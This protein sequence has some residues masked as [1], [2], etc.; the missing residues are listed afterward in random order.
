MAELAAAPSW[1]GTT[2]YKTHRSQVDLWAAITSLPPEKHGPALAL[3][4]QGQPHA[5]ALQLGVAVLSKPNGY[6]GLLAEL[7]KHYL[8]DKTDHVY[9]DITN[10]IRMSRT[11]SDMSA[12]VAR[13]RIL[14]LAAESHLA[15]DAHFPSAFLSVLL[16]DAAGLSS[17]DRKLVMAAARGS[18]D[19]K[20]IAGAMRR[21]FTEHH[22]PQRFA[23]MATDMQGV[24]ADVHGDASARNPSGARRERWSRSAGPK[25]P[26]RLSESSWADK[27]SSE[28]ADDLQRAYIAYRKAR[29]KHKQR[30][31]ET[32]NENP[33]DRK[34]GETL[35]CF[36]CGDRTHLVPRCPRRGT[37]DVRQEDRTTNRGPKKEEAMAAEC[38]PK[39]TPKVAATKSAVNSSSWVVI[40]SGAT[41][42]LL[43]QTWMQRH[44]EW[45]RAVG[46]TPVDIEPTTTQF[47]FGNG[48]IEAVCGTAAVP[49]AIGGQWCLLRAYVYDGSRPALLSCATLARMGAKVDFGSGHVKFSCSQLHH[50][51]K[52]THSDSGHLLLCVSDTVGDSRQLVPPGDISRADSSDAIFASYHEPAPAG[53]HTCSAS[54][55]GKSVSQS[56]GPQGADNVDDGTSPRASRPETKAP[57]ASAGGV[58]AAFTSITIKELQGATGPRLRH[59]LQKLHVSLGHP[60]LRQMKLTLEEFPAL[61]PEVNQVCES[62]VRECQICQR[63]AHKP[64]VPPAGK[65]VAVY[66]GQVLEIDLIF[67][68]EWKALSCVDVATH[69]FQLIP[70]ED[71]KPE[72]VWR[73]LLS[74]WM[75]PMGH[76][77]EIVSDSGGEFAG[78]WFADAC[79][80]YDI[81]LRLRP[82]DSHAF[83]AESRN[84]VARASFEKLVL[85]HP[86]WPRDRIL[87]AIVKSMNQLIAASGFTPTQAVFG[88]PPRDAH[89]VRVDEGPGEFV[90]ESSISSTYL[91]A[92][93]IRG[94]ATQAIRSQLLQDRARRVLRQN[95]EYSATEVRIGD[96]VLFHREGRR[97]TDVSW[98]GPAEVVKINRDGA[99]IIYQGKTCSVAKHCVRR[100]V[101]PGD[102]DMRHEQTRH[103]HSSC[104][105]APPHMHC[106]S[107][108][109]QVDTTERDSSPAARCGPEEPSDPSNLEYVDRFSFRLED[110]PRPSCA[111]SKPDR[112][113]EIEVSSQSDTSSAEA[114]QSSPWNRPNQTRILASVAGRGDPSVAQ[115]DSATHIPTEPATP[116]DPTSDCCDPTSSA[117]PRSRSRS[118]Y[119]ARAAVGSTAGAN[120][121]LFA[122]ECD[123]V[124]EL[125]PSWGNRS[126][127]S[128]LMAGLPD[129]VDP[130][131]SIHLAY[132]ARCIKRL[133]GRELT[134]RELV[135]H[136]VAVEAAKQHELRMWD[137]YRA[138]T[139]VEAASCEKKIISC[140]WVVTWKADQDA[141]GASRPKARLVVRGFQ[142]PD[143]TNG[144]LLLTASMAPRVC[145]FI[146]CST[147]A[148]RHWEVEQFD[149]SVAF[150]K[151][152]N[153]RRVVYVRPPCEA[154]TRNSLVWRLNTAVY[155]L[156]D[157]PSVFHRTLQRFLLD[158][159][160]WQEHVAFHVKESPLDECLSHVCDGSDTARGLVSTHVDDILVT[161]TA[162]ARAAVHRMLTGRFETLKGR[163]LPMVHCGLHIEQDSD[164]AVTIHQ[165]PFIDLLQPIPIARDAK[166]AMDEAVSDAELASAR[167]ILG[168][169]S[170]LAHSSRPDLC[171]GVSDVASQVSNMR[172]R[173]LRHINLLVGLAKDRAETHVIRYSSE[174]DVSNLHIVA[175]SDGSMG[176]LDC[177]ERARMGVIWALSDGFPR[178]KFHVLTWQSKFIRKVVRSSL[179]AE[180]HAADCATALIPDLRET[181]RNIYHTAPR[182]ILVTGCESFFAHLSKGRRIGDRQLMRPFLSIQRLLLEGELENVVW[183]PGDCHPCDVLTAASKSDDALNHLLT[184]SALNRL[185]A[186]TWLY[187]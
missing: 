177:P 62:I 110:S 121:I 6:K 2:S 102:A 28:S 71:K 85:E 57:G 24:D 166:A 185:S 73:A 131:Y 153:F 4:L 108:S 115:P 94:A 40:D 49:V 16:M 34:T 1:D 143:T 48:A 156:N 117:R 112:S 184:H 30:A 132:A 138:T 99:I 130:A 160:I 15:A 126:A 11:E 107:A 180:I 133:A 72:T 123:S 169:L 100:W 104:R 95:N 179:G 93:E 23:A 161:G 178:G 146:I 37:Y 9:G 97:K 171:S 101:P 170:W 12:F 122:Q 142:D 113:D 76:P 42:T 21:L 186:F 155:G 129:T 119:R 183:V 124:A 50:S 46:R 152:D 154:K 38:E 82:R 41:A 98:H 151:S 134:E 19:D 20:E 10:F 140:R 81:V 60:S 32:P 61:R 66:F 125:M 87:V 173:H 168:Q 78:D 84:R 35:R 158:R 58:E 26:S 5:I 182:T 27:D 68:G 149:V 164:F 148:A 70:V 54:R 175:M 52:L 45:L 33:K 36:I 44:N 7:D 144:K 105:D 3:R 13:F 162:C 86:D 165:K 25:A 137:T 39:G 29:R 67:L 8:E 136:A 145:H 77:R 109:M 174:I 176:P 89:D 64:K 106:E 63:C 59:A 96:S 14:Q 80:E 79:A 88:A 43:S 65:S 51:Q 90:H 69:Y 31:S 167:S 47:K 103:S 127:F 118:P 163:G 139:C 55:A 17:Q 53:T 141:P 92:C 111:S 150:L 187:Q 172:I 18:L 22:K 135:E 83:L 75:C 91:R 147:A 74:G 120:Q 157:A 159:A 128:Q 181:F 56:A 114:S 116:E